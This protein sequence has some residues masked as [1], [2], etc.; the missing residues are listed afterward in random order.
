VYPS[1]SGGPFVK[2]SCRHAGEYLSS[3]K[4]KLREALRK[5]PLIRTNNIS[6]KKIEDLSGKVSADLVVVVL[7]S[8]EG[9]KDN[10]AYKADGP[11]LRN[12]FKISK[13]TIH[14]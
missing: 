2:Q 13:I 6:S 12:N 10:I 5:V 7:I 14:L 9:T 1:T 4:D 3:G 8:L 11:V